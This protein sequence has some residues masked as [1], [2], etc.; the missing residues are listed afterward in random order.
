VRAAGGARTAARGARAG[1]Q[2][3]GRLG[4][5]LATAATAGLAAAVRQLGI[6]EYVRRD[7]WSFLSDLVDVLAPDGATLDE[8]IARRALTDTLSELYGD[9]T[10]AD[11]AEGLA[12][13]TPE[14]IG[15]AVEHFVARYVYTQ[16]IEVL[17]SRLYDSSRSPQEIRRLEQDVRDYVFQTVRL[18][19][20]D[21]D[22]RTIDLGG[23]D[24]R[25]LI[26]DAFA[27][28]YDYLERL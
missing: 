27:E 4:A 6:E 14:G 16:L 9:E 25:R 8:A 17:G 21:V 5:F 15:V 1:R 22:L 24:G 2:T 26:E 3:A 28:G 19:V 18:S 13:L 12:R 10:V 20:R 11:A 23:E 7:V